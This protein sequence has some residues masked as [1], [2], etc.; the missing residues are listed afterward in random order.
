[1]RCSEDLAR[2]FQ[3]TRGH[4]RLEVEYQD[5]LFRLAWRHERIMRRQA[6]SL[7]EDAGAV[8]SDAS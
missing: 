1:L 4:A 7:G 3:L 8:T 2:R 6:E 5:G